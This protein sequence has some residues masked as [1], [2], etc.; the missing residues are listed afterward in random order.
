M[1]SA[2]ARIFSVML[3][4]I[5]LTLAVEQSRAANQ[6][7][8]GPE[9]QRIRLGGHIPVEAM[10]SARLL[11]RLPMDTNIPLTIVLP[12][13]NQ[14]DLQTTL[15]RLYDSSDPLYG[16][17]LTA[18]QFAE[19]FGPTQEEYDAIAGYFRSLGFAVTG[20]HQNRRLLNASGSTSAIES[21]FNLHMQQYEA[22]DGRRFYASDNDPEVPAAIA[23]RIIGIIGL[24]SA[25]V[26]HS[27]NVAVPVTG[28]SP[29]QIGTGPGGGLAPND[30][31]KAYNLAA[32]SFNGAGQTLGLFELDGY[33]GSDIAAY[34]SNFGLPSV[35][36]HNVLVDGASGNPGSGAAEVTL[37]IELHIALA[38]GASRI[39]VYEAPNSATGVVD[40]YDRIAADN[41]AK[42]IST[43]WGLSEISS[44]WTIISAENSIFLQMAAQ[45]QSIYAAAGDQGAYDNGLTLSVDDPAS[46]PYMVGVGGTKL[47]VNGDGTYN[48]E[49]TWNFNGTVNG[50]AGGG[51]ISSIW[52][53]PAWQLGAVGGPSLGSTNMRNVPDVSLDA[54]PNT[55]YSI[56]FQGGWT[57][58]GGTSCAAPLWAAFTARVNQQ[59]AASGAPPLGFA[60]LAIYQIA[61][62]AT[63]GTSFHD[64]AD[65]STN[66]FYPAVT[67]YD[68]A[69]GWGSFNGANLLAGLSTA[70]GP[71]NT[72]YGQNAGANTTGS[73][74]AFFGYSAGYADSTG[75]QNAF[76]G[77]HAGLSNTTSSAN[78]FFGYN[79]GSSN[80]GGSSNSFF[81]YG[82]GQSNTTESNN[83]YYGSFSDG[84][85]GITNSTAIGYQAKV[86]QS[87]SLVL[88]SINGVNSATA[89]TKVGIGTTAPVSTL[90]VRSTTNVSPRGLTN[91][92]YNDGTDG[93][94]F[95]GR[96]ARGTSA[97]PT[98]VQ[99]GDVL[100][101]YVF[102]GHDG[103]AFATGVQIRPVT[104]ET[105]TSTAH[106][107]YLALWTTPPGTTTN[108]EKL[109]ITGLG[110][111]GIGTIS[112][113][114]RLHVVG[115]IRATGSIYTQPAIA[116]PDYVFK[117]DYKLMPIGE[118]ERYISREKHLPNLPEATEITE[119]GLNL[120]EFQMKLLEKIEELTL[121]AV[122][123][124]KAVE[125][126][127]SEI[128]TVKSS[129]Q[130]ALERK[131]AE[132]AMLNARLLA[133]E[134]KVRRSTKNERR[135][136]K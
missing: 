125:S 1:K 102:D 65:A 30:I 134:R 114:E 109:R 25:A 20:T 38:P 129:L 78:S 69:T 101:N 4:S 123:Q 21:A 66:L 100:G 75:S 56:Y 120:T 94:Q 59:R 36:L 31:S 29:N 96:K 52:N 32:V 19:K 18:E 130:S 9:A 112:P 83:S 34:V 79:A 53:I 77:Y 26:W 41:L 119:K 87:N 76:F 111:V 7:N 60:N 80:T 81:G 103:T 22:S 116:V 39:L 84:A 118:L 122:Q 55:G 72:S 6:S 35:S 104:E 45:G 82:A 51:G 108:T 128:A 23:S 89:D 27:H 57:I 92:Q 133:L 3:A 2:P 61:R 64:I 8:Q 91:E 33:N 63:Y 70:E 12:L 46:Q 106:G 50:G 14:E 107:A 16:H 127:E 135:G 42:Q 99:I 48:H 95:R 124:S 58:Y 97:A 49:T 67:G 44:T 85:A 37:D 110:N 90:D 11:G 24:D 73:D 15:M 10:V 136:Q 40:A 74:N 5:L 88:G 105:W 93:V 113:T 47:F 86:T 17:Y 43:S 71:A 131:D 68:L 132:I 126:R 117:S 121:Y 98:A 28:T 13:R 62:G 115:N 54:D